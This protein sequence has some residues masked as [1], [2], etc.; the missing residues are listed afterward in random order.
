MTESSY[1]EQIL[2]H[3]SDREKRLISTPRSWFSLVG[4]YGLEEGENSFGNDQDNKIVLPNAPSPHCGILHLDKEQITLT[5]LAGDA[6]KLNG[7]Q[8]ESRPLR[9]DH[10][11]QPDLI[12]TGSYILLVI[13]RGKQLLLR[14]WDRQAPELQNFQG[15]NYF[16]V[17]P[18]YRVTA[19]F[20]P[21]DPPIIKVGQDMIGTKTE[22]EFVGQAKFTINGTSCTLE[23]QPDDDELLFSFTDATKSDSTYPGGR[24]LLADA[25]KDGSVTL[26]FNLATNWPCAY[27]TF[28]TCPLPPFENRLAVRIEAGEKKYHD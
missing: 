25:P 12:E 9:N 2:K 22:N 4:L 26:D 27:T 10:D 5:N 14:I 8:P 21:Y 28:A 1:T 23:A 13:K 16:P 3:R 7:L 11:T 6:V 17:N 20:I 18:E 24:F 15:L 19:Q